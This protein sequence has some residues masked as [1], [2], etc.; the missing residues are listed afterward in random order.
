MP[1]IEAT[2]TTT[3]T[4]RVGPKL[5]R[6]IEEEAKAHEQS[7]GEFI[8]HA[9]LDWFDLVEPTIFKERTGEVILDEVAGMSR[10]EF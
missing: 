2:K 9:L 7:L 3:I 5:R 6:K 4:V 1:K 10:A 8:R